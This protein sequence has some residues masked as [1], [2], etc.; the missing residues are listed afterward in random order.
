MPAIKDTS[1]HTGNLAGIERLKPRQP[2]QYTAIERS[3]SV[4]GQNSMVQDDKMAL[5]ISGMGGSGCAARAVEQVSRIG[6]KPLAA[7]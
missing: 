6:A 1:R 5:V 3:E 4:N 2:R 7:L